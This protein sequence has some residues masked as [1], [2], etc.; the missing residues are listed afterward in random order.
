MRTAQRMALARLPGIVHVCSC[1]RARNREDW[2]EL[3]LKD[4]VLLGVVGEVHELRDCPCGNTCELV[5]LDGPVLVDELTG[6]VGLLG[7][8]LFDARADHAR[9]A[10]AR[11]RAALARIESALD[12]IDDTP[13]RRLL[14]GTEPLISHDRDTR[15]LEHEGV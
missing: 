8:A 2:A 5:V 6:Y 11:A 10:I 12:A 1:G 4:R 7:E 14:D 3:A 13:R 9:Q 15:E